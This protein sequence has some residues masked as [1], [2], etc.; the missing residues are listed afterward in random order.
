MA[1]KTD[2]T[3]VL[4]GGVRLSVRGGC[5]YMHWQKVDIENRPYW[6]LRSTASNS[7]LAE[8]ISALMQRC[9]DAEAAIWNE[10]ATD[11]DFEVKP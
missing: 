3:M 9:V 11:E 5:I 10:A 2:K 7:V 8:T 6:E 1:D 4:D